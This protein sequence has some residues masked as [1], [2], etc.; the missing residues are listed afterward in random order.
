MASKAD[1]V[2]MGGGAGGGKSRWLIMEGA[3]YHRVKGY[4]GVIFRRT[5]PELTRGGG[6]WDDSFEVCGH[7]NGVPR[8]D[9]HDWRWPE[10]NSALAFSHLQHA[11]DVYAWKSAQLAFIGLDEVTSFEEMMFWY[12]VSRLRS[13]CGVKPSLRATCNPEPGSWVARFLD[14]WIGADGFPDPTRDGL[15]RWFCRELTT[16]KILWADKPSQLPD[17]ASAKS[18]TFIRSRLEDNP[19]L[20]TKDP[21]YRATLLSLPLYER[22]ILLDGNWKVRKSAGTRFKRAWFKVV[23]TPSAPV[24]RTLRYWDRAG[25]EPGDDGPEPDHTAGVKISQLTNGRYCVRHVHRE[26]STPAKVRRSIDNLATQDGQDCELW[27]EEDPGQ[28]GKA[29]AEVL[30]MEL[31]EHAPQ[32]VRPTGSKWDRSGNVSA[33]AENGLVEVE[34]GEWNDDFFNELEAFCDPAEAKRSG[35]SNL[36]DD[37]VD[38]LSGGFNELATG[39][40]Q[41]AR[42]L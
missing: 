16:G 36:K 8:T 21:S 41:R 12:M 28:A 22:K 20:T 24:A 30:A 6:L 4:A 38:G 40:T 14:W 27:L 39:A 34:E 29:E 31:V 17:P 32:F 23:K 37:Q 5:S 15:L 7:L 13:V 35:N 26:Q 42:S 19:A 11:K 33:A 2:F 18:V 10:F 9:V 1:F 3:R 25:T